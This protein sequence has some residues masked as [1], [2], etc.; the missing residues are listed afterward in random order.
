[1]SPIFYRTRSLLVHSKVDASGVGL[2]VDEQGRP[3]APGRVYV[4]ILYGPI[5]GCL[6]RPCYVVMLPVRC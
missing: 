3:V 4:D 2:S 5:G 6:V 1:M